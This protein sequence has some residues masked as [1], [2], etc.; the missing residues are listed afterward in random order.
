MRATVREV[1][2]EMDDIDR[3]NALLSIS[4]S[5]GDEE[6]SRLLQ[7]YF[8]EQVTPESVR[9][10]VSSWL[11][12][13]P[14]EYEDLYAEDPDSFMYEEDGTD[15]WTSMSMWAVDKAVNEQVPRLEAMQDLG[16]DTEMEAVAEGIIDLLLNGGTRIAGFAGDYTAAAAGYLRTGLDQGDIAYCF[17]WD[18][19]D[20]DEEPEDG[21]SGDTERSGRPG[22][23]RGVPAPH[24]WRR[25]RGRPSASGRG[26]TA[27]SRL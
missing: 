26:G 7:E 17:K 25:L 15:I 24:L 21:S 20:L 12:R 13:H 14:S 5:L 23:R 8:S 11:E 2:G 18:D 6:M 4:E 3:R 10:E 19:V 22:A 9:S 1:I 27:S 16:M